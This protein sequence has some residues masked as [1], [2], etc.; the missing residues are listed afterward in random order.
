[1]ARWLVVV[2]CLLA[3]RERE[4]PKPASAPSPAATAPAPTAP[5]AKVEPR[6]LVPTDAE[7]PT[8]PAEAFAAETP[9]PAWKSRTE[10]E[11]RRRLTKLRGARIECKQT[12]CVVG[13][14]GDDREL[15]AAID[16]LQQLHDTAQAMVLSRPAPDQL[17]AY[18][19]FE[20]N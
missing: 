13:V 15:A 2:T 18:L 10:G 7:P 14:A 8:S 4:Q 9:D 6:L 16:E 3:C 12:M 17:Q 11:L 1:M 5:T 20:R 19:R